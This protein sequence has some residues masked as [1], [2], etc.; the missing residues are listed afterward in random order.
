M[1][2][3]GSIGEDDIAEGRRVLRYNHEVVSII[4]VH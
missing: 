2:T 1:E 4:V 3:G